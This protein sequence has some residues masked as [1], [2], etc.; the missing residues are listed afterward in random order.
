M[1]LACGAAIVHA[2]PPTLYSRPFNEAPVQG[3]P[4]DLVLMAGFGLRASDEVV[5]TEILDGDKAPARPARVPH[6]S[7][8]A[9]GVAPV[10]STG[11]VPYALTVKL[12]ESMRAD[13]TYALWVH[14]LNGE[15]SK[16]ILINDARPLWLSPAYVYSTQS[17]P[18]LPRELKVIGRN[19]QP[20]IGAMTRVQ[21]LGPE[22]FTLT[23]ARPAGAA[24]GLEHYVAKV[25]LPP[26]L[27][28]GRYTVRLSRDGRAWVPVS[29]QQ[30]EIR[31]DRSVA[32]EYA[33]D[34][35]KFGG[36]RPNDGLD[37]TACIAAAIAAAGRAGGGTVYFGEGTW[38][39][40]QSAPGL[41]VVA[42]E[43]I[44]VPP[45]VSLKG[46]GR[47]RTQIARHAEW[48]ARVDTPAF[49]LTGSN[50][51][52]GFRFQDLKIYAPQDRT[53]AFLQLGEYYRRAVTAEVGSPM[54]LPFVDDVSISGNVFDKTYI[55]IADGGLPIHRLLVTGNVF[56]AYFEALR[57]TGDGSNVVIPYRIDDSVIDAN[58]FK[59][60]GRLDPVHQTGD[61][62]S[63]LGAGFRVD[64]SDNTADGTA[65]EFLYHADDPRG[66]EAAFFWNMAN[67]VEELLVSS[68][69]ASCTGDRTGDGAAV[70]FDGNGN[71]FALRA[72]TEVSRAGASSVEVAA[73]L[74]SRQQRQDIA[75]DA[76]YREHWVQ[77]VSG[78]GLGQVRKITS[79]SVSP[80]RSTSK[81]QVTPPWDVIPQPGKS[82]IA[83]GK[84]FWQVYT[85]DNF[86][87]HRKPLCEKSNRKRPA[88]GGIGMWAQ[89]ADSVIAGNRQY[90]T[91]GILTQ[92]IYSLPERPCADCNMESLLQ[93]FLE[94]RNN[95][96]DGEYDWN[97]DCSAS[98]IAAGLAAAPWNDPDPPTVSYGSRSPTTPFVGQTPHRAVQ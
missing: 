21:L 71:T 27:L 67:N 89:T 76:F 35:P 25:R 66:W 65:T 85:I 18:G 64:F 48:S 16:P 1:V 28:P 44:L 45:G 33:V 8:A 59:P 60:G 94:I 55:A 98:G 90:D 23:V 80:D 5:Y 11:S 95:L 26:K 91:D 2:A 87:D 24:S 93:Y 69:T 38:D 39:L 41:G 3:E 77:V 37:D 13:Q 14:T 7:N 4:N 34:D 22:N 40:E 78:P 17:P 72:V 70:S 68:N 81:F 56:G 61:I 12:P 74:V 36:C 83:V 84:E 62:G 43:G 47:D 79:Y 73:A 50:T 57:L 96:I 88:G 82:R 9:T 54:A 10:V 75:A 46:A 19:L 6:E 53:A 97:N 86:I 15:W 58:V 51:V 49:T 63:E 20:A 31:A 52:G 32:K 30:L 92:Q 42:Y 29:D